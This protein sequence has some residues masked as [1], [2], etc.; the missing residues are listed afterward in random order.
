[1]KIVHIDEYGIVVDE[2]KSKYEILLT[3]SYK[4]LY[5][6]NCWWHEIKD[7]KPNIPLKGLQVRVLRSQQIFYQTERKTHS[8]L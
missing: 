1:M 3:E 5:T 4:W 8:S 7:I 6:S 2:S